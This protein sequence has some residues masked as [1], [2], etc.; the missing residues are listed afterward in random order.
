MTVTAGVGYEGAYDGAWHAVGYRT[1]NLIEGDALTV[2]M[3]NARIKFPGEPDCGLPRRD[4]RHSKR[5]GDVTDNY[6]P[7]FIGGALRVTVA[8]IPELTGNSGTFVYDGEA[9]SVSGFEITGGALA[10]ETTQISCVATGVARYAGASEAEIRGLRIYDEGVDVTDCYTVTALSGR[11]AVTPR[12]VTLRVAS[13]SYPYD[14]TAHAASW[15]ADPAG[16][17]SGL[18]PGDTASAALS[19]AER[20][21]I[22]KND[23]A[24]ATGGISIVDANGLDVSGSYAVYSCRRNHRGDKRAG[25]LHGGILLR[26]RARDGAATV[27]ATGRSLRRS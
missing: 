8:Q 10:N 6:Q 14:G 25:R 24:F 26:R 23:V 22:G 5:A 19:G 1:E 17:G 20:T 21:E 18:L 7:T 15:V 3:Q 16:E 4:H 12:P 9:H 13:G 11:V 27:H 2:E